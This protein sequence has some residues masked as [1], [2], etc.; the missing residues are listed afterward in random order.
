MSFCLKYLLR[1]LLLCG[2]ITGLLLSNVML[3]LLNQAMIGFITGLTSFSELGSGA[4]TLLSVDFFQYFMH[5]LFLL[6]S[7]IVIR[8]YLVN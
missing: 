2:L 4:T 6:L 1:P 8:L 3:G 7:A 5:T